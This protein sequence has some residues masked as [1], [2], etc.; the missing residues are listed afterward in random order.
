MNFIIRLLITAVV[1]YFLPYVL[2]GVTFSGFSS[3]I[4]FAIV[5]AIMNVILKPILDFFGFPLTIITF[6]LFSFVINAVVILVVDYFVDGMSVDGFWWALLF[7]VVLSFL[8]SLLNGIFLSS[9][10]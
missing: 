1:A 2:T 4:V 9:D 3:A 8:T 10:D 6:G 5:L 7:G